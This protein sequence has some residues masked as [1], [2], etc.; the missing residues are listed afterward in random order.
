MVCANFLS[1]LLRGKP[2]CYICKYLRG[3]T[4]ET[5]TGPHKHMPNPAHTYPI[6]HEQSLTKFPMAQ[7]QKLNFRKLNPVMMSMTRPGMLVKV[8]QNWIRSRGGSWARSVWTNMLLHIA[9]SKR[10]VIAWLLV[11]MFSFKFIF[12]L[13]SRSGNVWEF[14]ETNED[15]WR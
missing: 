13:N 14:I 6:L 8:D 9:I 15:G 12:F 1:L 2:T 11:D 7:L 4:S 5:S 3:E 10:E